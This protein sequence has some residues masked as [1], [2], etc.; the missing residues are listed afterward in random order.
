M[1][2]ITRDTGSPTSSS[3]GSILTQAGVFVQQGDV[4]A[5]RIQGGL[6]EAFRRLYDFLGILA[7]VRWHKHQVILWSNWHN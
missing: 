3:S 6:H 2:T 4:R 1:P 7:G 5:E